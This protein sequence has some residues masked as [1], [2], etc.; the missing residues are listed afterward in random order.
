MNTTL[1]L[2]PAILALSSTFAT[3]QQQKVVPQGMDFVESSLVYTYPFG[4]QTGAIQLLSALKR[5]VAITITT[6]SQ[7]VI[8]GMT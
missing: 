3:A 5:P 2:L 4:R 7:Y 8:K 6:D 1:R